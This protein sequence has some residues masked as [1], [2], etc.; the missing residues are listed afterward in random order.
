LGVPLPNLI[1]PVAAMERAGN[2]ALRASV[3]KARRLLPEVI[4]GVEE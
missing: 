4:A 1:D 3:P 2:S